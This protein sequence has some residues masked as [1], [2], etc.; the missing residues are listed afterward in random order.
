VCFVLAGLIRDPHILWVAFAG[1]ATGDLMKRFTLICAGLALLAGV[2][3]ADAQGIGYPPG[4][5][6]SNPQDLTNRSNPQNLLAPGGSNPQDL[7]RQPPSVN[8]PI[9]SRPPVTS[10]PTSRS[11]SSA[12]RGTVEAKP[13]AKPKQRHRH[14]RSTAQR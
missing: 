1:E 12:L 14:R 7:V 8:S 9:T 4:V 3:A 2:V 13:K 11:D 6:P 5:N 10:L